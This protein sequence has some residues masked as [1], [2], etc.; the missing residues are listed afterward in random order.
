MKKIEDVSIEDIKR[1]YEEY[2]LVGRRDL[3]DMDCIRIKNLARLKGSL[4]QGIIDFSVEGYNRD[5]NGM[6]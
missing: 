3:S 2:H 6:I 4:W 5:Q 1:I